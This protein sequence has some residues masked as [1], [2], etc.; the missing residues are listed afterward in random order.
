MSDRRYKITL[1][2]P[3]G[4]VKSET[5]S[6]NA[7]RR[8]L[9][10][11]R[12]N[13]PTAKIVV[14][15]VHTLVSS[16]NKDYTLLQFH[17]KTWD[18][19]KPLGATATRNEGKPLN[20]SEPCSHPKSNYTY[21]APIYTKTNRMTNSEM[22][23]RDKAR[24]E[25]HNKITRKVNV[26]EDTKVRVYHNVSGNLIFCGEVKDAINF[27]RNT[28]LTASEVTIYTPKSIHAKFIASMEKKEGIK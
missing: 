15:E 1:T 19:N 27:F 25:H 18:E 11:Y 16:N 23:A 5:Y 22:R 21:E 28:R 4:E 17:P 13:H 24:A 20:Q 7:V 9:A 10:W 26:Q 8:N 2:F 3:D 12:A 6:N 14:E